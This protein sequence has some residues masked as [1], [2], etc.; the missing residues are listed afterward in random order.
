MI[1]LLRFQ[2]LEGGCEGIFERPDGLLAELLVARSDEVFA[3]DCPEKF[4]R[5]FVLHERPVNETL[6]VVCVKVMMAF[7]LDGFP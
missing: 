5:E 4:D 1:L 6:R 7:E 2:F 3:V